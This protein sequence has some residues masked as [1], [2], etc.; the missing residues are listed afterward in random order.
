[1]GH[2][3]EPVLAVVDAVKADQLELP[4]P[5][6]GYDVRGLIN[7]LAGT[8][9]WLERVGRRLPPEAGDPFGGNTDV[10][11]SD[12]QALLATR[13]RAM[14]AAWAEPSAW[15]G[16]I[17]D[18]QL[19]ATMIGEMALTELLVHGWDLA[20]A[21]GQQVDYGDDI[22]HELHRIVAE[23]AGLGRQMGAY[24]AEVAVSSTAPA[25]D[26]TLGLTG[27]DPNWTP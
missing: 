25:F 9:A 26:R 17:E 19:P 15:E 18:M 4:T 2:A 23:T 22:G 12:W 6:S 13:I 7:H 10:T 1:M 14:V 11:A 16:S 27:R 8:M 3:V 24:G 5:C 20:V 21:T